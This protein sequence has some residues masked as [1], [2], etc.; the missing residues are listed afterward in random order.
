MIQQIIPTTRVKKVI[1]IA[2]EE[3]R[4]M[5]TTYVGTEHLLVGSAHR[6]RGH[7]RPRSR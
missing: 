2:F 4:R 3:A 6:G 7:R 1:E 5:G